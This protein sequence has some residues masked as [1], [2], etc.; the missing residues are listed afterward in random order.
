[1]VWV[2]G[3]GCVCVCVLRWWWALPLRSTEHFCVVRDA[4][5]WISSW[6][7]HS[8]AISFLRHTFR[9]IQF[10]CTAKSKHTTV[11]TAPAQRHHQITHIVFQTDKKNPPQTFDRALERAVCHSSNS[12]WVWVW[13]IFRV[14]C[15]LLL[16]IP[17][18]G[19]VSSCVDACDGRYYRCVSAVHNIYVRA[20][21]CCA[22]VHHCI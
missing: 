5:A 20:S 16:A 21:G 7:F 18:S 2:S 1:M 19:L 12:K 14:V 11:A 8:Q 10:L 3:S 13:C 15:C 4:S 9:W 22:V 17:F 6:H